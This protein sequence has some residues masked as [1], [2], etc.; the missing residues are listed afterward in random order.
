MKGDYMSDTKFRLFFNVFRFVND[1]EYFKDVVDYYC[2]LY[3]IIINK[4][5][6]NKVFMFFF[7]EQF[8]EEE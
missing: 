6:K 5:K 3:R 2:Y 4:L 7:G 1:E 8:I